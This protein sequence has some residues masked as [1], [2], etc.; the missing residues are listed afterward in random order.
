VE[1][2]PLF[3]GRFVKPSRAL[4]IPLRRWLANNLKTP[5]VHMPILLNH[6]NTLLSVAVL[7]SAVALIVLASFL[8]PVWEASLF[9][10]GEMLLAAGR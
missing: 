6:N 1:Q 4:H 3:Q 2:N 5:N 9:T 8:I 10:Y 7:P